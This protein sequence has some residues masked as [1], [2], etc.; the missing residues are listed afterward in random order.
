MKLLKYK[1]LFKNYLQKHF[2][3]R[4]QAIIWALSQIIPITVIMIV[5]SSIYKNRSTVAGLSFDQMISYYLIITIVFQLIYTASGKVVIREEIYSGYLSF[6]LLKPLSFLK[7]VF[8]EE[9]SWRLIQI[10]FFLPLFL[11]IFAVFSQQIN[12]SYNFKFLPLFL[13]S[14]FFS[15]LISAFLDYLCGIAAFWLTQTHTLFH[16]KEIFYWLL[17]GLA[18]PQKLLPIMLQKINLVLP[19]YYVFA[20]PVDLLTRNMSVF[21]IVFRFIMQ[22]IWTISLFYIY[23]FIWKKGIKKYEA[24]GN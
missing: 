21:D 15:F 6:F 17:G 24:W 10:I 1:A 13:I 19:F 18:F 2:Y 11:L 7:R 9:L 8:I 5:W 4:S 3:F 12:F 14:L 16:L 22:I 23:K 20:F